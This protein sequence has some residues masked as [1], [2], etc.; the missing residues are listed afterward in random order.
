MKIADDIGL[1]LEG[2]GFRGCYTA[3]AL[4]WLLDHDIEMPYTAAISATAMYAFLY[5]AKKPEEL[6]AVSMSAVLDPNFVGFRSV[7]RE[8][9]L[10]G[11]NYLLKKYVMPTYKD[12]LAI[13][14]ASAQIGEV[15]AMNMT[16]QQLEYT[17]MR[18]LDDQGQ[19]LKAS[20]TLPLT[21]RITTVDGQKWMDG[22]IDTMVSLRRSQACGH[23]MNLVI[24]TKDKNY[25]RKENPAIVNF[26]LRTAYHRYP[27]MLQTL[28]QRVQAYYD[29]MQAVYDAQDQGLAILI[30]PTRDCGVKRFSGT[31]DQLKEMFELGYHDME[32]RKDDILRL[33]GI[34][35]QS[36]PDAL[37]PAKFKRPLRK[38]PKPAPRVGAAKGRKKG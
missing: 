35:T 11:Y 2:G 33:L 37:D 20:C 8:G 36:I 29:Q 32:E 5:I 23:V 1:V 16:T 31:P 13:I 18:D 10:V 25:V 19:L 26:M 14:K 34:K 4:K 24:V 12:N 9:A 3:G 6:S 22:G 27:R 21:G 17:D 15:G 38:M 7:L 30:R 28:S